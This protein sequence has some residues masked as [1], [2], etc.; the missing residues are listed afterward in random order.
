MR[1][2]VGRGDAGP[3]EL[4]GKGRGRAAEGQRAL[5]KVSVQQVKRGEDRTWERVIKYQIYT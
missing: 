1:G 4:L 5:K 3:G 2:S